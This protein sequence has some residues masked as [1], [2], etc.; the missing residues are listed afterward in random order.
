MLL[1]VNEIYH[2][3]NI[4]RYRFDKIYM[5]EALSRLQQS[6]WAI[7]IKTK[8]L[9]YLKLKRHVCK[10]CK[11]YKISIK[12]TTW[13]LANTTTIYLQSITKARRKISDFSQTIKWFISQQNLKTNFD[14]LHYNRIKHLKCRTCNLKIERQERKR[15]SSETN[16]NFIDLKK[17]DLTL[18]VKVVELIISREE[19]SFRLCRKYITIILY[20]KDIRVQNRLR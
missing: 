18:E 15:K 7:V 10:L 5:L 16:N 17:I 11:C 4:I 6:H 3:Y 14:T 1:F 8:I 9:E 20:R 12:V 2:C 19:A 13:H